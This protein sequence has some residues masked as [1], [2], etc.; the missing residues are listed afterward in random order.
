MSGRVV[1]LA[2]A[3][4]AGFA[5][6]LAQLTN[7]GFV[8]ADALRQHELNTRAATAAVGS[9]RGAITSADG[10]TLAPPIGPDDSSPLPLRAYPHGPLYAHVV[11][12]VGPTGA[13]GIERSHNDEL[14]GAAADIAVQEIADLFVDSGRVG[15]VVLTL[16]HGVQLTARAALGDRDGAVIVIEPATGAVVAMW[17]R[18]SFDP[19]ALVHSAPDADRTSTRRSTARAYRRHYSLSAEG[20]RS[21]AGVE[22]LR[23]ARRAPGPTG[24][25]LPGEPDDAGRSDD[26]VDESFANDGIGGGIE[27]V[28]LTPLQLALSAAAA[29]ND[30]VRMRPYIVDRVDARSAARADEDAAQT[31]D[32]SVATVPREAG[33][34]FD[35][36][37]AAAL[38]ARMTAEAQQASI[39]LDQPDG[40]GL[41][42][43]VATGQV[44]GQTVDPATGEALT[45]G[46]A[47]LLAPAQAPTVAVAVLIEPDAALDIAQPQ[48]GG[49]LAAMIAATT[50]EAALALR[51]DS[52]ARPGSP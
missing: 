48:G 19:N 50:A 52:G 33:R 35:A 34:L 37:G 51:A 2:V 16:H 4:A 21:A 11:G 32:T 23:G 9:A 25:D 45:G 36:A 29:A 40:A 3:L 8:S 22:L 5:V 46:W 20:S 43:A 42:A 39:S 49:T 30:G 6:L 41:G 15:D 12:H 14:S 47:V 18:P 10:E 28:R 31:P 44:I 38:L 27:R 26:A 24:I 7:L 17:S 1:R 13:D